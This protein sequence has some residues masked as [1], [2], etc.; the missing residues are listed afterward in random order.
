MYGVYS[1]CRWN[2]T[3]HNL[4]DYRQYWVYIVRR[5]IDLQ[6]YHQCG[7]VYSLCG[8]LR[9]RN[10]LSVYGMYGVHKPGVYNL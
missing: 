2:T 9:S 4:Y 8:C 10:H 7:I 3:K 5:G 6:Y 1:L